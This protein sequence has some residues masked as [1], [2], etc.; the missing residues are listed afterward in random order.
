[1][2]EYR[3]PGVYVEE[4]SGGPRP[5]QASATTDTG[6]VAVLTLPDSFFAGRGEASGLWLPGPESEPL[7][8]WG[9]ALAFRALSVHNEPIANGLARHKVMFAGFGESRPAVANN[10]NGNTPQNRRVEVYLVK[11]TFGGLEAT[12]PTAGPS[13]AAPA[14]PASP[15]KG[16]VPDIMK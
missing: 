11:S 6:F 16:A 8:S 4:V 2:P 14:A 1:M 7:S 9:R 10:P 13:G 3:T 5:V 15:G 12:A